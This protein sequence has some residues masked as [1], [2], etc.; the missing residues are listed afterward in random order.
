MNNADSEF[1]QPLEEAT[2]KSLMRSTTE[3]NMGT[4]L[5]ALQDFTNPCLVWEVCCRADSA[6]MNAVH[7][8]KLQGHRKT[9][10]TGYDIGKPTDV[11][12]MVH[13]AK[14]QCPSIAWF[15]LVCTAV[16]SIQNLNQRDWKQ[17]DNLRKKRQRC[18]RQ[19]RGAIAIIWAIIMA[20]G[21]TSKFFFEWPKWATAGWR[22]PELQNFIKQ[23]NQEFGR[24]YFTQIDGC[25]HGMKSPDGYHIQKSWLIL[26]NDPE[27]HDKCGNKCDGL[28]Q[29]RPGGMIGMG[30]KAVAE[31]AFYPPSMVTAIAR[32]WRSQCHRSRQASPKEIYKTIMAIDADKELEKRETK[33]EQ[34][35]KHVPKEE[36]EK[37]NAMLHRLHRAA[38][39]PTNRSLAR[40]C[41]DRG[42]PPWVSQLALNL[43]CQA[44]VD[45]K[46]GAQMTLPASIESRTRPWQMIG[47]DVF[48][49]YYPKLKVKARYLLMTCLTMRFTSVHLLWQGDMAT[50]GTDAG[51]KLITAFVEGW[52]LHRPRP[53]WLLV[54]A[55]TSLAKGDFAAFCQSIGI[56]ISAVPGEAHWQHGGT[57][58]MVKAIKNTM[59][60]VRSEYS[61]LSPKLVAL[62]ASAAQNHGDRV[63][64]FSP[65]QWAYGLEPGAWHLENDP[66]E[67]NVNHGMSTAEFWQVQKNREAVEQIHRKELAASR[68]T[69]LY[70]ASSRPTNAYMVG[71][72]VCVWRNTT[73]RARKKDFMNEARFIG[74]G[75][76][77][78]IEP[79]VTEGGQAAVF[80]VLMGTSLWRCAPEQLRP[81]TEV[82]IVTEMVKQ[83]DK[84]A[85]PMSDLLRQ[86]HSSVDVT[87]EPVFD[88]ERDLL[89][90]QPRP[91]GEPDPGEGDLQPPSDER[92][93]PSEE[94]E[95]R[96]RSRS[97]SRE[98]PEQRR[99]RVQ[100]HVAQWD[101][102]QSI[103]KARRLEGLPPLTQ[104]PRQQEQQGRPDDWE[105]I[106]SEGKLIRH[107]YTPR[108]SLFRPNTTT[109]CPVEE[110]FV[111]P[112]RRTYWWDDHQNGAYEDNWKK[113]PK[114]DQAFARPWTGRT[115][116]TVR[117][118]GRKRVVE[119]Y[120]IADEEGMDT[121][122][123]QPE[124]SEPQVLPELPIES[125]Y[126][127]ENDLIPDETYTTQNQEYKID[128]NSG[129]EP[130]EKREELLF[131]IEQ[132]EAEEQFFIDFMRSETVL[133]A[134]EACFI[135]I[136]IDNM[137]AFIMDS[138]SY[139]AEKLQSPSKEV[140]FRKL[141]P[142]HQELMKEA[143]AREVSEVLRS[144]SLRALREQV[145]DAVLKER[146]IPMRWILIWK[147]LST[148]E[149]PPTDGTPTVLRE[150]GM[151][152]A[153]ARVVL[154]GYKHPDLARRDERTGRPQ[155]RT[156]SPTLSRLGR[157]LV[158]QAAALDQHLLESADAKS[159][160]LQADEGIGTKPLYTYAVP[161]ISHALHISPGQAMQV[162][163]AVYGLTNAPR[164]FWKDS[165]RKIQKIGGI[166]HSLDKC[167]W[168]FKNSSNQVC[169]RIASHV[170]DFII[171]GKED[172]KDWQRYRQL[173][174]NLYN[175]SPWQAGTFTFAGIELKQTKDYTIYMTQET[176]C[177][178][179]RPVTIANEH[180]RKLTDSL[181]PSEVSQARGLA[182]KAQWRAIQTAPQFCARIGLLTSA[183][184][185]PTLRELKEAN[186]IVRELRKSAKEDLVLHSFNAHRTDKLQWN[187]LIAVHFADAGL[188]NRP[189]GGSTGGHVSCLSDPIVLTGSEAKMSLTGMDPLV[190]PSYNLGQ[191]RL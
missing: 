131:E 57:E 80:W 106:E 59:K 142:H 83:G 1:E 112:Q 114:E 120:D 96:P 117:P 108:W 174:K 63:K 74:P 154:I 156:A 89:P 65:V 133:D 34:E 110:R 33:G 75:R 102:L 94:S 27:F 116:F 15:S 52:L 4:C 12:R 29:H 60:K 91:Q 122:A 88:P 82:E 6:L 72:W 173:F 62:L 144:Q 92:H 103:N 97:R 160:F 61:Q 17:V 40:L 155:L 28:H 157:Q 2:R 150:D 68:M 125:I 30:S 70:N 37:T 105:Y 115:E 143:M 19:L 109:N 54:D 149:K 141:S 168:T 23:Y 73:L 25:M 140:N 145:P 177:N 152:K 191:V 9:L 183:L 129:N 167:I 81:A 104:F 18:R 111:Q 146:I 7:E 126:A 69:R 136:E 135:E 67:V 26:H 51:Q 186:S 153:K 99:Q 3:F 36:I 187:Q 178:A 41:Q 188:N 32:I 190:I 38:G 53:E 10:E 50:T 13:E 93:G 14:E 21:N 134:E 49:L 31:T 87:K 139:I 161:E 166:P 66:L 45:T 171:T 158:L 132:E 56:G 123:L 11:S 148:P 179:L 55:Q 165:D 47:L 113:Q 16:T 163:G 128:D 184:K 46:K 20:S 162:V 85:T 86:L 90:D 127:F 170:D 176:F 159:A 137:A 181:S 77:A 124:E 180:Q 78:M 43:R 121:M 138:T 151:A 5:G 39:H 147:P 98:P 175:W 48:E 100:E 130:E 164:I 22:L 42:L 84:L 71:D 64:G 182:M 8:Q 172:D 79:S 101:Q 185:D 119:H 189:G 118:G 58:S 44:C 169:G 107:H 35:L 95:S 24:L 76:I